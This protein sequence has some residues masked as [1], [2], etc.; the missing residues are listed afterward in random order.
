MQEKSLFQVSAAWRS[1][2]PGAHVGILAMRGVCSSDH[3]Q[4]LERRKRAVEEELRARYAGQDRQAIK[5]LP[6]IQAY[7][8]YYKR[9]A[10]TYHVQL[11]VESIAFKGREIPA[12][13]ALVE[14]M[15]I[16]EVKNMLLTAGHDL[17]AVQLPA[18]LGVSDGSERY[19]LLRGQEQTLKPGDMF[20][21]DSAGV[22]SSVIYGPDQRTQIRA[23]TQNALFTVYAP[24]GIEPD[25][26]R[27]HL[28]DIRDNVLLVSPSARMEMLIIDAMDGE[29]V[30]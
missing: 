19:M 30:A 28:A 15:F 29:E 4:E 1:T 24:Q 10:K 22:I 20:V 2:F 11:Q 8:A 14:C 16:A 13:A 5:A 12:V 17:D 9:F 7:S 18:T 27:S 25:A 3:H 23:E 6:M 26:V 21:A